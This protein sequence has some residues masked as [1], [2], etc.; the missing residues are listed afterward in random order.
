[1][2]EKDANMQKPYQKKYTNADF[3]KDGKL[4]PEVAKAAYLDMLNHYHI[5]YTKFLEE[6]LFIT[7]FNLGD[8]ENVGMAGVFWINNQEDGYFGHEI[9][10]LPEQM[11][12]EHRHLP[13]EMRAKMESW[14]IRNGWAYNFGTGEETPDNP[15]HPESQKE[16]ITVK[17][18]A[19]LHEGEIASLN[20]L[21]HP[22]F[23][24]GGSEGA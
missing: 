3:Y 12:V 16:H 6:N 10:L 5:P 14:Q 18:C 17:N 8:M 21:E 1:M 15:T 19:I 2:K 4:Q 9:Y 20:T 13:T 22:H 11:I 24:R 7:D 23:L